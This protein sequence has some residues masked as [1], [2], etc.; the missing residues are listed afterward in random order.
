MMEFVIITPVKNEEKYIGFTLESVINQSVLPQEWIIVNDYSTDNTVNIISGYVNKY[1]WIKLYLA[2]KFQ[3]YDYSSRVVSL[4]NYGISLIN[5]NYDFILKLDGD[6]SFEKDFCGKVLSEFK[7]DPGL[8]IA[9][10]TITKSGIPEKSLQEFGYTRGATKF[11]RRQCFDE[12]GGVVPV[13]SWD[14]IDNA[15]ARS[16]G[17][18]TKSLPIYFIHHKEE[19]SRVGSNLFQQYRT[20]LSNGN[21]PYYFPYFVVKCLSKVRKKPY[22]FGSIAQLIGFIYSAYFRRLRPF[23]DYA[24]IQ[25]RKDQKNFIYN[26]FKTLKVKHS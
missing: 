26:L 24:T 25:V 6:V 8:G 5:C 10:G 13:I 2:K 4:F 18:K 21:I 16:K 14:T 7:N 11:Y 17:W 20:G 22:V 15:A 23:P 3:E 19:G 12:I 9:S 1:P